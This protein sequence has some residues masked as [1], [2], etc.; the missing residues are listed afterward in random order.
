MKGNYVNSLFFIAK[1]SFSKIQN[2][3]RAQESEESSRRHRHG[4]RENIGNT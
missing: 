2:E 4:S 1:I 3:I